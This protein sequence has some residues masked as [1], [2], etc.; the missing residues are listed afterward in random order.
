[1][2]RHPL[3]IIR[4]RLRFQTNIRRKPVALN[5]PLFNCAYVSW[6]VR[7]RAADSNTT[8]AQ[9]DFHPARSHG[10]GAR[11]SSPADGHTHPG[12]PA[13]AAADFISPHALWSSRQGARTNAVFS[14]RAG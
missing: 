11:W 9:A 6:V 10:S 3:G 2:L 1:M 8:H 13:G 5:C 14:E 12:R 7:I 4:P